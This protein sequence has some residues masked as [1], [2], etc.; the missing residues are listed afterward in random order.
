ML[1]KI[2]L[3]ALISLTLSSIIPQWAS[4]FTIDSEVIKAYGIPCAITI[5]AGAALIK[6]NGLEIGMATCIAISASTFINSPVKK[7]KELEKKVSDFQ[8]DFWNKTK[9]N[10]QKNRDEISYFKDQIRK[11]IAK[12]IIESQLKIDE[13]VVEY[14]NSKEF[15]IS[16][17]NEMMKVLKDH[18]PAIDKVIKRSIQANMGKTIDEVTKK[19]TTNIMN[20]TY[21][22][23]DK[24]NNVKEEDSANDLP[25][26]QLDSPKNKTPKEFKD[27]TP[28]VDKSGDQ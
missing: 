8:E 23:V 28:D 2:S 4:A 25:L 12:K 7:A 26:S 27:L 1:R 16:V 13:R 21:A 5:G 3:V 9:M 18:Y 24:E 22:K 17:R 20:T 6:T 14:L 19:V 10:A 15:K 11:V